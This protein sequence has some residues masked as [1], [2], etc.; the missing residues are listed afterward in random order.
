[1]FARTTARSWRRTLWSAF[2]AHRK[3]RRVQCH[4][5]P[6]VKLQHFLLQRSRNLLHSPV[7]ELLK[8][9]IIPCSLCRSDQTLSCSYHLSNRTF[10]QAAVAFISGVVVLHNSSFPVHHPLAC[11][12]ARMGSTEII[13]N[14]EAH[15]SCHQMHWQNG[16]PVP[17]ERPV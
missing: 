4:W 11:A 16:V 10:W 12:T 9:L 14:H 8:S 3:R 6:R 15:Q 13:S 5:G 7:L 1:M 2:E 17:H